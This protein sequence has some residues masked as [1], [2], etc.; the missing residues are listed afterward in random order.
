M[1]LV[2]AGW[3]NRKIA[4]A[5]VLSPATVHQHLINIYQK[6]GCAQPAQATAYPFRNGL[7]PDVAA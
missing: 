2:A 6:L 1:G 5:L 3:S 7:A 4:Q